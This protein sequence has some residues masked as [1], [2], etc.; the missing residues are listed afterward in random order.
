MT[1]QRS[2]SSGR[3]MP[4][5][6]MSTRKWIK[7]GGSLLGALG[8]AASLGATTLEPMTGEQLIDASELIVV[9]ECAEMH[10]QWYGRSLVTL[11]TV[12]VTDVLKGEAADEVTIALPGGLDLDGPVPV[13]VTFPGA[14]VWSPGDEL[15]LFLDG[16]EAPPGGNSSSGSTSL[17]STTPASTGLGAAMFG[18]VGFSQGVFPVVMDGDNALITQSRSSKQGAMPLAV[19]KAQI[20][21]YIH[22]ASGH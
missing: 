8:L 1:R 17:K 6:S 3:G 5:G 4:Q 15:L 22:R 20:Q 10:A 12:A 9:G 21:S 2:M 16:V 7:A 14:P 13:A 11:V 18:V 19:V